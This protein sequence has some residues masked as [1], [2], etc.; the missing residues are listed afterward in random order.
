MPI[1]PLLCLAALAAISSTQASL[2]GQIPTASRG[3]YAWEA[4]A[5]VDDDRLSLKLADEVDVE[6]RGGVLHSRAGFDL[7]PIQQILGRALMTE[8]MV[9]GVSRELLDEWHGQ[10]CAAAKPGQ[11][12]GHLA[13]WFRV[14]C[15]SREHADQ[16]RGELR[17][18]PLVVHCYREPIFVPASAGATMVPGDPAPP[19]P[20]FTSM[21]GTLDPH[22]NGTALRWANGILGARGQAVK[23]RMVE[24]DW[25]L[26]HE[27]ISK[28]VNSNFLGTVPPGTGN[29]SNHGVA[30]TSLMVAD[31]NSWGLTG[32]CDEAD[33]RF[34]AFPQNGGIVNSIITAAADGDPGDIVLMVVMLL[35]PPTLGGL[36]PDDWVPSEYV[37]AVFDAVSTTTAAGRILVATCAN[38]GRSLDDPRFGGAFDRTVRDSGAIFVGATD[39]VNLVRAGFCNFGNIVD[40]NSWGENVVAAG[41]GGLFYGNNDPRQAYTAA[42]AGT[43]ASTPIIAACIAAL[44]GGARQQLGTDLTGSQIRTLLQTHGTTVGLIGKRPDLQAMFAATGIFDGLELSDPDLLPGNSVQMTVSSPGTAGG[45]MLFASLGTGNTDF[46]FN[47]P[48]HLDVTAMTNLDFMPLVAGQATF[49]LAVPNSAALSGVSLYLQGAL[50]PATGGLYVTNSGHF[51][52]L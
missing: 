9:T 19:T 3:D 45:A 5:K 36:G 37:P 11:R 48:V 28:L 7:V 22:P 16:L 24:E 23:I 44:Q 15:A 2:R 43:S 14:Q 52:V 29:D 4:G 51:T 40:S 42:Y 13:H 20:L 10:A 17:A 34:I 39:G 1:V 33:I 6:F 47:R 25:V 27:D 38:G 50:L 46:G 35:L 30:G 21:Q 32:G 49:T 18:I 8:S 31:R 26:D 41:F 12:P